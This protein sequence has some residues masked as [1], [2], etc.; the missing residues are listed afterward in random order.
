MPGPAPRIAVCIPCL[1]EA[2]PIA[3]VIRDFR[4]ALPEAEIRVFDN[5]SDDGTGEVARS[6]GARVTDV[7]ARGKGWVVQRM[8]ESVDADVYV[9]VDGDATY[10]ASAVRRLLAPVL[11]GSAD[12][13]VGSRLHRTSNSRFRWLNRLGNLLFLGLVNLL[14]AAQLT[15]ILSGYRVFSRSFVDRVSLTSRGFEIETEL[16]LRALG[17]GQRIVELPVDLA[18]RPAGSH[19]KIKLVA[20]GLRI[21]FTIVRLFLQPRLIRTS[22]VLA[23]SGA[24]A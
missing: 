14:F 3:S 18:E 16:T 11:A 1:N 2:I 17:S 19:S 22:R 20:D 5:G 13:V 12:M 6:A 21:L 24:R 9:M 8:F 23:P 10:P 15:D 7:P 4:A